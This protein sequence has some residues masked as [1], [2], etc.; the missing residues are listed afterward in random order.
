MDLRVGDRVLSDFRSTKMIRSRDRAVIRRDARRY[1]KIRQYLSGVGGVLV[2]GDRSFGM[3]VGDVHVIAMHQPFTEVCGGGHQYNI[4]LGDD[5]IV[6]HHPAGRP[7]ITFGKATLEGGLLSA[8]LE[9]LFADFGDAPPRDVADASDGLASLVRGLLA[10]ASD[11]E[12]ETSIRQARKRYAQRIVEQNLS[13]HSLSP[14]W[15]QRRMGVSRATLF[16]DLSEHGGLEKFMFKTRLE[17]GFALLATSPEERGA[18]NRIAEL[19]GFGAVHHFS[20]AF[21]RQFGVRPSDIL[22]LE[23]D[24][25][26]ADP[27][28]LPPDLRSLAETGRTFFTVDEGRE[29]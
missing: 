22:G 9:T 12:Q 11:S 28:R 3:A 29:A 14:A 24:D 7:C 5:E 18:V 20:N 2:S 19:V 13:D 15:L 17:R 4:L 16:R 8:C 21:L 25:M 6:F 23:F 27:V 10:G 26:A 1:L